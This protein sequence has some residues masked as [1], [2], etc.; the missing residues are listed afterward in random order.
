MAGVE[1]ERLGFEDFLDVVGFGIA[2][3]FLGDEAEQ[4]GF[5]Q[6]FERGGV[7]V[8]EVG[9][10][11]AHVRGVGEQGEDGELARRA[12][13]EFREDCGIGRGIEHGDAAGLRGVFLGCARLPAAPSG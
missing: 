5:F 9:D 1:R 4:A 10:G 7:A 11:Q 3:D 8:A 13:F 6:G 12:F 2:A